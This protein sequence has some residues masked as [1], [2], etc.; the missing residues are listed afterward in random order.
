MSTNRADRTIIERVELDDG[1]VVVK[2]YD[3]G[4]VR[5]DLAVSEALCITQAWLTGNRAKNVLIERLEE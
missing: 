4:A 3:D 5:V 1:N 2:L